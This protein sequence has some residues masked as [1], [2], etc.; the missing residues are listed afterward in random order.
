GVALVVCASALSSVLAVTKGTNNSA[1]TAGAEAPIKWPTPAAT[2]AS[3]I[4]TS[5]APATPREF[6]NAGTKQLAARK[7]REAE[8]FLESSLASQEESL[9]SPALYNLG[10]VRFY[11]GLEELK[12]NPNPKP[13]LDRAKATETSVD[14]A[15]KAADAALAGED[16]DK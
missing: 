13:A 14:N 3:A 1:P 8:A 6:F 16:V 4:D 2:N 7:Y 12:K 5:P 10:E 15:I 9:Q 11:Q